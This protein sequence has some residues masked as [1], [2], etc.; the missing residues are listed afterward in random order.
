MKK[1]FWQNGF[2][3][4]IQLKRENEQQQQ[5]SSKKCNFSKIN[6]EGTRGP[7]WPVDTVLEPWQSGHDVSIKKFVDPTSAVFDLLFSIRNS[8]VIEKMC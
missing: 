5:F 1:L 3:N 8:D 4:I 6:P 7:I 2:V